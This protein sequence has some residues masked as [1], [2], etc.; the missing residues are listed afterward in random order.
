MLRESNE[1]SI[2]RLTLVDIRSDPYFPRSLNSSVKYSV[3]EFCQEITI[4]LFPLLKFPFFG[5]WEILFPIVSK[6][7][8]RVPGPT[9]VLSGL[10]E[11]ASGKQRGKLM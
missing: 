10:W 3:L 4:F 11:A 5:I 8:T 1:V 6:T 9:A 2:V 7:M